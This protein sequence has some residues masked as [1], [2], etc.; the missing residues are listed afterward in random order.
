VGLDDPKFW[1]HILALLA[2]VVAILVTFKQART[3]K[4]K[5]R[6]QRGFHDELKGPAD[7]TSSPTDTTS[8]QAHIS[9]MTVLD[10]DVKHFS[11]VGTWWFVGFAGAGATLLAEILDWIAEP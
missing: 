4:K 5:S 1:K 7:T 6:D 11:R 9:L 2:A 3:A 10:D 8:S